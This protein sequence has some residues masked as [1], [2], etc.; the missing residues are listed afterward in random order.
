MAAGSHC[1]RKNPILFF[2]VFNSFIFKKDSK[3]LQYTFIAFYIGLSIFSSMRQISLTVFHHSSIVGGLVLLQCLG[4]KERA[5]ISIW[6][7]RLCLEYFSPW[8]GCNRMIEVGDKLNRLP[9]IS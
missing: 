1:H 6:R 7:R 9:V 5:A 8:G 3:A 2:F 4:I